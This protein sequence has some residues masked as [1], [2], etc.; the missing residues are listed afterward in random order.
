MPNPPVVPSQKNRSVIG[1]HPPSANTTMTA[2]AGGALGQ[3]GG[4]GDV[5]GR[6]CGPARRA[7]R[8]RGPA[9]THS[10]T[11]SCGRPARRRTARSGTATGRPGTA[12]AAAEPEQQPGPCFAAA[13]ATTWPVP[14]VGGHGPA[15]PR[16]TPRRS[17]PARG[18]W[19]PGWSAADGG[20]PRPAPGPDSNP[21]NPSTATTAST[22]KVPNPA[23]LSADG[24]RVAKL[25]CPPAGWASPQTVSATMTTISAVSRTPRTL[26]VM[27]T[28]SR[29]STVTTAQAPSA[30][31]HHGACTP[32]CAAASACARRAERAVQPD[33]QERV[34]EQRDQRGGHPGRA[35]Q[36]PGDERVERAAV[37]DPPGHRHVPGR[38]TAPGSPR[39]L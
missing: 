24:D 38:R 2:S 26:P 14:A 36:A 32:R 39:P 30:H 25:R 11:R 6:R 9:R 16:R 22:P 12:T 21:T 13:A 31:T 1:G 5:V 33:L 18:R 3:R 23:E 29:P 19:R 34:G 8:P 15:T 4:L 35:A 28:R 17:R 7:A 20:P 37:G 27:S 10:A